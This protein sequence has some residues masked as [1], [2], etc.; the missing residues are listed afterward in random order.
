MPGFPLLSR[1]TCRAVYTYMS[2]ANP[3]PVLM[4]GVSPN[5]LGAQAALSIAQGSPA[6]LILAARDVSKINL[7]IKEISKAYPG[8]KTQPLAV[9]LSSLASIRAAAPTVLAL[10]QPID[11]LINNAGIMACPY[12]KTVDGLESQ[13]GV[14]HVSHFLFTN[15]IMPKLLE[16]AKATGEARIVNLTSMA[17]QF[18]DIRWDDLTF[19][20]GKTYD[21]WLAY[22]QSKTA[23]VVFTRAL[24]EKFA[25]R[26][27]KSLSLHPGGKHSNTFVVRYLRV[28]LTR[29]KESSHHWQSIVHKMM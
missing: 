14:N 17:H 1:S 12:S 16:A 24:V 8:V 9:D 11:V 6:L 27:I 26:G 23:N 29:R 21:R 15:L 25:S 4:T 3:N 7:T 22:G 10:E 5:G 19:D 13:F 18:S 20:D 28:R 2:P